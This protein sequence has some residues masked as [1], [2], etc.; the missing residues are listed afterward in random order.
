M[1]KLKKLI[2]WITVL[3]LILSSNFIMPVK[4][5]PTDREEQRETAE[6]GAGRD[7]PA[8]SEEALPPAADELSGESQPG[9]EAPTEP[10]VPAEDSGEAGNPADETEPDTDGE[11][12]ET[13][14]EAKDPEE[15]PP[16][17]TEP[18]TKPEETPVD[19]GSVRNNVPRLFQTDYPD[20]PYGGDTLATS[21]CSMVC[22]AMVCSYLTGQD[23]RPDDLARR[24][25]NAD[26]SHVQRME[27]IATIYDLSYTKTFAMYDVVNA[28]KAG[29][30]VVE[31]VSSPSP[32]SRSQHLIL[33]TGISADGKIFVN[34]P[35]GT[36]Y[37]NSKLAYG[38]TYGFDQGVLSYGFS[39]A[40]I[41]EPYHFP[42]NYSTNYPG[43]TL[44]ADER[45]L[46]AR[47]V[48]LEA[49]GEPFKGQQAVA[50]VVLNRLISDR[51]PTKTL[52]ATIMAE[53]Q[54]TTSKFLADTIADELQYKAVDRAL[55]GPNV[56][57]TETFFFSR[58]AVN[59][60]VKARIGKHA[61]CGFAQ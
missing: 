59:Q 5:M 45:D 46:L 34:D 47:M 57:D 50:E 39:G 44:T 2:A 37:Q 9:A 35:L 49:R 32:F 4:S 14:E 15:D 30:L 38:F 48:W 25:R 58:W 13:G 17:E 29:K 11:A 8:A 51:F 16:E 26:G 31:M 56:L 12:G 28:L 55:N 27:A 33:L 54:F 3:C 1:V 6:S 60:N 19:D 21:G 23:V 40:W 61:F 18:E 41:F 20:E 22:M 7:T 52:R 42:E 43:L 53:G 24:F 36:N 10:S